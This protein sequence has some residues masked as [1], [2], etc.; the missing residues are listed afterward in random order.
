MSVNELLQYSAVGFCASLAALAL[1]RDRRSFVHR[2]FALGMAVLALEAFFNGLVTQAGLPGNAIRWQQWRLMAMAAM[3]GTWLLFVLSFGRGDFRP[4]L[5]KRKWVVLATF[6]IPLVFVVL[7]WSYF[8]QDVSFHRDYGWVFELSL[9]GYVFHIWF[10]L[11]LVP[12]VMI[13]ERTLRA[14]T[15]LTRWQVKFL[16]LGIGGIFAA[17]IYTS[18]QVLIIRNINP[19]IEMIN[20]SALILSNFLILAAVLR[21][22]VLKFDIYFSQRVLQHS[23]TAIL[24]GAYL[25][26]VGLSTATFREF[27]SLPVR[28]LVIFLALLGLLIAL[29]SDRLRS[30]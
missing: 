21:A 15:G 12:L 24:V 26:A 2:I 25:T 3:S 22:G 17:R 7:L 28:T 8:F 1:I 11:S 27:L 13:L 5:A 14:S 6:L 9:S 30:N 16:L 29:L 23:L 10:L 4:V 18:S 20:A 19:D